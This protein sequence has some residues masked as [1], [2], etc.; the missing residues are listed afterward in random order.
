MI[1]HLASDPSYAAKIEKL[2]GKMLAIL[3]FAYHMEGAAVVTGT[4]K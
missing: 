3:R 1:R 4:L 2:G